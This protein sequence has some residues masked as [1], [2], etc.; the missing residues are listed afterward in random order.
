MTSR[1]KRMERKDF[2]DADKWYSEWI[3]ADGKPVQEF[4]LHQGDDMA[5]HV[6]WG[7]QPSAL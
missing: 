2:C 3:G 6:A 4:S 1:A 7:A 5:H